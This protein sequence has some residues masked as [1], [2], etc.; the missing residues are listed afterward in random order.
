VIRRNELQ[1]WFIAE[2]VVDA[3]LAQT[4]WKTWQRFQ[5][6]PGGA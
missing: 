5:S 1:L 6:A 3:P 2:H 4:V